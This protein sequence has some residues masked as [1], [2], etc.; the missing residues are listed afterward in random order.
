MGGKQ[1]KSYSVEPNNPNAVSK[2]VYIAMITM[3]TDKD[4]LTTALSLLNTIRLD[5]LFVILLM[6]FRV[7]HTMSMNLYQKKKLKR[8]GIE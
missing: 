6:V 3:R 2:T 8:I 7:Y 1:L 4:S 5:V